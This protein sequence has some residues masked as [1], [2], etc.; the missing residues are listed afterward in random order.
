MPLWGAAAHEK[1][2]RH[3]TEKHQKKH[4]NKSTKNC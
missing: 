3:L 4:Q 1:L 2:I